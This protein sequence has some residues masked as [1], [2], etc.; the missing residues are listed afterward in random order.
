M[1]KIFAFILCM[2]AVALMFAACGDDDIY[3]RPGTGTTLGSVTEPTVDSDVGSYS[4][5]PDGEVNETT[6]GTGLVEEGMDKMESGISEGMDDLEDG[7]RDIM[8]GDMN[9]PADDA[10]RTDS[11]DSHGSTNGNSH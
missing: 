3:D 8:D 5:D 11:G 2:A 9:N 7:A 10:G 1:K 4:A 6:D